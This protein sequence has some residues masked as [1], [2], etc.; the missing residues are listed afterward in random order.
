MIKLIKYNEYPLQ[1]CFDFNQTPIK[2][3]TRANGHQMIKK[4]NGLMIVMKLNA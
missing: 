2:S 4:K 1:F 3:T